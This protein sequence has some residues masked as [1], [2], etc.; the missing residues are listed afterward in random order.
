MKDRQKHQET[1][2]Q[3]ATAINI[4]KYSCEVAQSAPVI[5]VIRIYVPL[6]SRR[7]K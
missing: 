6:K 5:S 3:I 2:Q 1:Q 7:L 4:T